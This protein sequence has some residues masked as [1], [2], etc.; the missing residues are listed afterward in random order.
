MS[1][2]SLL[3]SLLFGALLFSPAVSLECTSQTFSTK[4]QYSTC[5][6]LPTLGAFLHWT[7]NQTKSTLAVAFVAK[8][9]APDGWIAWGIN[10]TSTGMIGAQAFIAFKDSKGKL[11]V[12]TYNLTSYG[13]ITQQKLSL[14]VMDSRA[15]AENGV[16]RI[17][18]TVKLPEK[19]ETVNQVWQVGAAVKDNVPQKHEMGPANLD[20]KDTLALTAANT[21]SP[22]SSPALAPSSGGAGKKAANAPASGNDAGGASRNWKSNTNLRALFTVLGI[23]GLLL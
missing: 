6:D 21:I 15:E 18:A 7:Y 13:A 3:L 2:F 9:A 1:S 4:A 20:A 19:M 22:A 16:M 11:A 23:F 17:F 5:S 10:P 14:T 8:P 12:K